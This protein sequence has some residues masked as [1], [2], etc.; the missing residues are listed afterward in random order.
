MPSLV[1]GMNIYTHEMPWSNMFFLDPGIKG[2]I[3]VSLFW[4][5][6]FFKFFKTVILCSLGLAG[7]HF[8]PAGL[9][10]I[11][12]EDVYYHI[13]QWHDWSNF[14]MPRSCQNHFS[15]DQVIQSTTFKLGGKTGF[16]IT[17]LIKG[18]CVL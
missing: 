4:S 11:S 5:D 15:T 3:N 8:R 10:L 17:D 7:T 9:E 14:F 16:Q 6:F 18:M 1:G 2:K 12:P 13:L